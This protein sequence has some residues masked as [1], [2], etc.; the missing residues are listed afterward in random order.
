MLKNFKTRGEVERRIVALGEELTIHLSKESRENGI[1]L[2]GNLRGAFMFLSDLAKEI[3]LMRCT[4]GFIQT[5][6]KDLDKKGLDLSHL[7][8]E[9]KTVVFV[10]DIVDSGQTLE[11]V[12]KEFQK[13][14]IKR[15]V[16]VALLARG[17]S[18]DIVD[19]YGFQINN[20]MFVVGYGMDDVDGSKRNLPSIY[21][22]EEE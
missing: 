11:F 12:K 1:V 7:Q 22:R 10:D 18:I 13:L 19:Y 4:V 21:L 17:K 6:C 20:N 14:N 8:V 3:G 5:S 15:F 2:I 9:G 16:S